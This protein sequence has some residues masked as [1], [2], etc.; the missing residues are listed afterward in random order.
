MKHIRPRCE[1][2]GG[3]QGYSPEREAFVCI[4]DYCPSR[5]TERAAH[6]GIESVV[7][8]SRWGCGLAILAIKALVLY[9]AFRYLFT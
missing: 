7:I 5:A 6:E 1:V 3:A 9:A 4:S 2:C 8:A